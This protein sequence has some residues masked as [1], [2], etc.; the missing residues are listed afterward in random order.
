MARTSR[1]S[2]GGRETE[3]TIG[4]ALAA[5]L[6]SA[7]LKTRVAPVRAWVEHALESC[8][9]GW[10]A[11]ENGACG[12]LPSTGI[13][14]NCGKGDL[15]FHETEEGGVIMKRA[16]LAGLA[17]SALVAGAGVAAAHSPRASGSETD[18]VAACSAMMKSQ[19]MTEESPA[20]MR[21]Y[22]QSDKARGTMSGMMQMARRMGNDVMT[23]V[24]QMMGMM[25]PTGMM[26][27]G[28]MMGQG[29]MMSPRQP[30]E[31]R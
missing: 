14:A 27:P 17:V 8:W 2:D 31:K 6:Q 15:Q 4:H 22:M 16:L 26:S 19:G 9:L 3:R 21:E 7:S 20:A 23:G 13:P 24:G 18:A 25:G 12:R 5:A 11:H 10:M 29:G 28:S 30:S 1:D